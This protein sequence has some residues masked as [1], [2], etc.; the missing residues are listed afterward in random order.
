MAL[1]KTPFYWVGFIIMAVGFCLLGSVVLKQWN[2]TGELIGNVPLTIGA[3]V[4]GLVGLA[5][6]VASQK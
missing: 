4:V 5:V 1:K 2:L 6:V 3:L